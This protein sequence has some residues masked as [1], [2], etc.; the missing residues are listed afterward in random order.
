MTKYRFDKFLLAGLMALS[1]FAC[2]DD[3][4]LAENGSGTQLADKVYM[5]FALQ[6]PIISRSSTTT[7]SADD[8]VTSSD[9]E[10]I[11]QDKENKVSE[12][13][14]VIAS[15]DNKYID[16]SVK[17]NPTAADQT[18]YVVPF[19]SS[20][21]SAFAG[22]D[23]NVYV[24]C[25]PTDGLKNGI[26]D[27]FNVDLSYTLSGEADATPWTADKFLMSNADKNFTRTLPTSFD[28]YKVETNPFD[29]GTIYVERSVARF[30]YKRGGENNDDVYPLMTD[31]SGKPEVNI[32]LTHMALVNMS[33]S[34]YYLRRVSDDGKNTNAIIGG[35]ETT[36]NYMVDT[37][38]DLK[39]G[40]W[41]ET[42]K[43]ANF[44]YN[45]EDK[46]NYVWTDIT[47]LADDDNDDTWNTN[48]KNGDYKIWR[49]V[50]ENTIPAGVDNQK[51]G[52]TTGVVFKGEIEYT[53]D[54][55]QT[56]KNAMDGTSTVY[57]Y[58]NVMYGT[59]ADV[60][61]EAAKKE[62]DGVT[63]H[64]P[65][66]AAAVD[67]V[68][69]TE[70]AEK[71]VEAGF[72]LFAPSADKKYEVLYYYW[73]RHNDNGNNGLMGPMEFGVVRNNVYKLSVE[74]VNKFGHPTVPS[75]DP[76]PVNPDDPDEDDNVY[77]KVA[78]K[79]R[80]WVVRIN[81]IKF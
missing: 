78:V 62:S 60:K 66:L 28:N 12:I 23:V 63:L 44:F 1:T 34:F 17:V 43:S 39:A 49:Y 38:A 15:S 52:I 20:A 36:T 73:N 29:L 51:H 68:G 41:T 27:N 81:N 53:E 10:E 9:G 4:E 61:T 46:D 47:S 76:D 3:K 13:M 21:L 25:N 50:T 69:N 6:L 71:A 64:N 40:S 70:N 33:K 37:D 11:G 42:T 5:Q 74:K 26:K 65:S 32:K 55:P 75:N 8:Y 54:A 72:T 16:Q 18:T 2:N 48:N 22:K 19:N 24:Y 35:V 56:I 7:G 80:P 58:E 79:I 59:W 14:I 31:E 77:F 30:D 57:V 45:S 67:K